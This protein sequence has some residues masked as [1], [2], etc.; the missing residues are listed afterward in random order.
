MNRPSMGRGGFGGEIIF[1]VTIEASHISDWS[2][3]MSSSKYRWEGVI[4]P[5]VSIFLRFDSILIQRL[6]S[7]SDKSPKTKLVA[8]DG[9]DIIVDSLLSILNCL[10]ASVFSDGPA[11]QTYLPVIIGKVIF[12]GLV[13]QMPQSTDAF[14]STEI[15]NHLF[16]KNQQR[17]N[18]GLGE[19]TL[20]IV[21]CN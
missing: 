4:T 16:Q 17:E 18:F 3:S 1:P 2:S 15:T 20:F 9:G 12:L 5:T 10:F 21:K 11:R 13:S 14:F 6:N 19:W 8:D 7:S